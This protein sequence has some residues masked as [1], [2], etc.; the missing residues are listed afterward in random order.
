[1]ISRRRLMTIGVCAALVPGPARA[2]PH[3]YSAAALADAQKLGRPVIVEIFAYWCNTCRAQKQVLDELELEQ[4]YWQV[5][6]L[7]IDFD[8]APADVRAL[9]ATR[10]GTLI[11]FKG[12]QEVGRV[13]GQSRREDVVALLQ[14][15]L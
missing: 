14:R 6:R 15:G 5:I 2:E 7:L 10:Q 3:A 8:E 12:A 11:M 13:V 9:G 1:M 4:R